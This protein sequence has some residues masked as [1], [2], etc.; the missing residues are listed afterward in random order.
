MGVAHWEAW[1]E[2]LEYRRVILHRL[3]YS[4]HTQTIK[5]KDGGAAE[6]ARLH[7]LLILDSL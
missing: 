6:Q 3:L 1:K 4:T 7:C 2:V 5:R